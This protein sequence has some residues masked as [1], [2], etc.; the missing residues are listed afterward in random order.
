MANVKLGEN[1]YKNVHSVGMGTE[2]GGSVTFPKYVISTPME[3]VLSLSNWN[4]TTYDL[5]IENYKIGNYGVQVGMPLVTDT[6]TAQM[7]LECAFTIP[8]TYLKSATSSAAAYTQLKI[9]AIQTP[10]RD[11]SIYLFGLE[12]V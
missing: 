10:T 4:G 5:K 7:I 3:V 1:V 2:N 6:E 11:V 9:S 8:Y 12:A